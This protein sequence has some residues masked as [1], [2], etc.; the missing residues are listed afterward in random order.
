MEEKTM[1]TMEKI[2][3]FLIKMYKKEW[4]LQRIS[5]SSFLGFLSYL[6]SIQNIYSQQKKNNAFLLMHWKQ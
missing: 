6:L 2:I 4:F 5:L 3:C 1:K